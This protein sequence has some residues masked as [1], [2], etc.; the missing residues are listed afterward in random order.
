MRRLEVLAVIMFSVSFFWPVYAS[1]TPEAYELDGAHTHIVWKVERFGFTRTVGS[2]ADISGR[3]ILD[4]N[5]PEASSVKAV[6][7][8]KGL[9]SDHAEREGIIR[10]PHWLDAQAFPNVTFTSTQ[11]TLLPDNADRKMASVTGDLTLKGMT[12]PV[13]MTVTLNK[14]GTEPSSRKHAMGFSATGQLDRSDF[15]INTA[16]NFIGDSVS[17]EIEALAIKTTPAPE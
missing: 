3:L 2:F 10:G 9:R 8:L 11:V 12:H 14:V 5:D 13:T 16:I 6:I 1:A 15:G 7:F 17:F 4:E